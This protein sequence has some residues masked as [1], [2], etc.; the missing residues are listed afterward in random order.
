MSDQRLKDLRGPGRR[1]FLRWSATVAAVLGLERARISGHLETEV[2]LLRVSS[3]VLAGMPGE[4]L[5]R[6]GRR[7]VDGLRRASAGVAGATVGIIG[8]CDDELGYLL[9]A[10]QWDDDRYDYERGWSPSSDSADLLVD[11]AIGLG[12]TLFAGP[13]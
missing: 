2:S 9:A 8:L 6:P 4:L 12:E 11:R 3:L 7:L 5:P 13:R 10:E 1:E